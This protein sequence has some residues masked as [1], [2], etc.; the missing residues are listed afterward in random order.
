MNT[1]TLG[2]HNAFRNGIRSISIILILGLSIGLSL[3]MLIAHQAVGQKI[4]QVKSAIGNTVTIQP[5]GFAEG[6]QANNT[7]TSSQLNQVKSLPH[8]TNITESLSDQVPTTG[9]TSFRQDTSSSTTTSLY[10]SVNLN[11]KGIMIRTPDGMLPSNFSLPIHFLGTTDP[12]HLQNETDAKLASGSIIDGTKDTNNALVST[13]MASKNNLKIGSTFQAYNT[14]LTVAG[15]FDSGTQGGNNTVILAL[16]TIQRLTGESGTVTDATATVDSI[17]NLK[18]STDSIKN[19]LG[20]SADVQNSQD[21]VD[22]TIQPL[23]NIQT[24]SL[25]SLIGAIAAGAV[26][27]LMTMIMIVRERRREIGILKAIGA[28]NLRVITQ[29]MSEAVTLT[30][31]GMIIGV[32][33]GIA[34]GNPVTNVLVNNSVNAANNNASATTFRGGFGGGF[35][36][37]ANLGGITTSLKDIHTEV[38]WNILAYGFGSALAIA[39]VGSASAGWLIARVRPS[40]VMRIE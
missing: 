31:L 33:I 27:I 40:E 28:S 15:I 17:D 38:G 9:T 11:S 37:R 3:I 16:P 30:L 13:S 29:F 20:D 5:A 32:V 23:E 18:S 24:V 36:R 22:N 19:I 4:S 10:S 8:V 34:G 1:I 2:V 35:V 7:L 6:G 25:Y 21:Q 12:S 14:T 26:I 39:V